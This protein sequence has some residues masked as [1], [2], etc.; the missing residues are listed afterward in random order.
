MNPIKVDFQI[1]GNVTD[2]ETVKT[3]KT[4][5]QSAPLQVNVRSDKPKVANVTLSSDEAFPMKLEKVTEI[6]GGKPGD[7]E[8]LKN[9]PK[10]NGVTLVGNLSTEDLKIES[11]TDHRKLTNRD[12]SDQHPIK[13][14]TDL[15]PELAARP[16]AVLTNMDIQRILNS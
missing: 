11:V 6:P 16:S 2:F 9:K 10:I 4:T 3:H 14:I 13:A 12:A 8:G 1:T 15:E 5:L 7:Y